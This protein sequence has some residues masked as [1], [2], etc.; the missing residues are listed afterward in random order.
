MIAGCSTVA[1]VANS[2]GLILKVRADFEKAGDRSS[3]CNPFNPIFVLSDFC[4]TSVVSQYCGIKVY[5]HL[6]NGK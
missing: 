4:P 3:I 2:T 1:G 6:Y 5:L